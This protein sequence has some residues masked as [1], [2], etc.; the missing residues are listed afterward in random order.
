MV[1]LLKSDMRNLFQYEAFR[2]QSENASFVEDIFDSSTY[3]KLKSLIPDDCRIIFLQ[4]CWDGADMFNYSGKSMWPLCYSIMN[5]PP[6]L[7]DKP[8]VG[9]CS[10]HI[11]HFYSILYTNVGI[12]FHSISF[13]FIY[14]MFHSILFYFIQFHVHC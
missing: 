2:Y 13:H 4:A 6:S 11:I 14:K 8:H 12:P 10:L 9:K 5:L 1:K 3:K 7:R